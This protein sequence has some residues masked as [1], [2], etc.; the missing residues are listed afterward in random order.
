PAVRDG[1][2]AAQH[3]FPTRRSSDLVVAAA[4][5]V[6]ANDTDVDSATLTA[7]LGT[8]PGHGSLTL[9]LDGSFTYTPAAN[10]NG[11]DS[12]TYKANDGARNSNRPTS[13]LTSTSLDAAPV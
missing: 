2:V 11:A 7:V 1:P 12:F 4:P 10:F 8:G 13:T 3:C 5:G 9:N 6:L